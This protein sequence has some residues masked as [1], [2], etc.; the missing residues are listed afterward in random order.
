MPG[1][2][3]TE[4]PT[5][6]ITD[7]TARPSVRMDQTRKKN[8]KY[9]NISPIRNHR[10]PPRPL[11]RHPSTRSKIEA[12]LPV[13]LR[14]GL[15]A[16]PAQATFRASCSCCIGQFPHTAYQRFSSDSSSQRCGLAPRMARGW[17]ATRE[18]QF[19]VS[20]SLHLNRAARTAAQHGLYLKRTERL[21][22]V[23]LSAVG[24]VG[25][26]HYQTTFC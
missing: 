25:S 9:H 18:F 12:A 22:E 14:E 11:D 8:V 17:R 21:G 10:A 19:L 1:L 20:A 3:F 7:S 6:R 2:H 4:A 16:A 15:E 5:P 24:A 13:P 26:T 23:G